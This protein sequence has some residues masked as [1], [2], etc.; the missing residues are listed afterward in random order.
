[1]R[2]RKDALSLTKD[3]KQAFIQALLRLKK[4]GRYDEYVH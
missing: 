1:M 3:K 2:G 4:E